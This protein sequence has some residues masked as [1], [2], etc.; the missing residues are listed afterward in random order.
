MNNL[1][2]NEKVIIDFRDIG[3]TGLK[4]FSGFIFEEF[5][6]EL[7][8]W[9]GMQVYK[10]MSLNDPVVASMLFAVKMLCRRVS[11]RVKPASNNQ[12]DLEAAEFLESCMHDMSQ[13][14]LD[15]VDEELSMLTYGHS[16]HEICYKRRCGES[17]DPTMRSKH[18]DGRISWR[19]LPIRSQDTLYRWQFDDHGGIQGVEQLAPPHYYHVTIPIEKLLLFRTT[20]HKN[21]PQGQSSLRGAYRC[22][23]MKKNIENIE[24]IGIERDLAGLPVAYVPP[25]LLSKNASQDQ[26]D[27]LAAI[28]ELVINIRR[29]A[30]EGIVFP[31]AYDPSSQ[32]PIYDLKL[33][34]TGGT[35]QFDTN[36][37]IQRYDQR[38]AMVMLADF[39][40][41]GHEKVGSF[42]LSSSKTNIFS[43]AIGAFLDMITEV[44]NR[45]AV[46]RL[47]KLNDFPISDYPQL[48]HGDVEQVDLKELGDYVSKLAGSGY[49]LFPNPDL[50][51]YLMKVANLPE[52]PEEM[53]NEEMQVAPTE[54]GYREV[55]EIP[56]LPVQTPTGGST[57]KDTTPVNGAPIPERVVTNVSGNTESNSSMDSAQRTAETIR[58]QQTMRH[59]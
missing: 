23:Y 18:K 47:F 9:R 19:K 58:A 2:E 52:P 3:A 12:L 4:R 20:T 22:W 37:I 32:K 7:I 34:S 11:W 57:I 38:I 27:A 51:R 42:A 40:L 6:Q 29:D 25:E 21:N 28:K 45:F 36:Q 8:S 43:V 31:L 16:A 48:T 10:E 24:G 56:G 59:W 5:L 41:L 30:Q 33:L 49:P 1:K 13:P 14:W 39:I 46:P 35:R 44:K 55:V 50:E 53:I 15:T 17:L 54:E 26:K